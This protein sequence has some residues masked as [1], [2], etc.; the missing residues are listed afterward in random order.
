MKRVYPIVV[1]KS[2]SFYL[3][4]VP[5]CNLMTQAKSE[6]E[7]LEMARDVT[8]VSYVPTDKIPEPSSMDKFEGIVMLVETDIEN[9]RF[10]KE[11]NKTVK[12]NCTVKE[13]LAREAEMAGLSFSAI[14]E[15]GLL[16]EL[17]YRGD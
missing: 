13:W 2:D 16:E 17:G 1:T 6:S 12:K 8:E 14:L 11:C 4:E 7:I 3:I 10:R 9:Y 5:D 15:K